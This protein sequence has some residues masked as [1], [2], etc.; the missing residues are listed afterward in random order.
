MTKIIKLTLILFLIGFIPTGYANADYYGYWQRCETC[1]KKGPQCWW[2]GTD[3]PLKHGCPGHAVN[4]EIVTDGI[5][6]DFID[7]DSIILSG[8]SI[9]TA[10]QHYDDLVIDFDKPIS[11]S[12]NYSVK[13]DGKTITVVREYTESKNYFASLAFLFVGLI[14]GLLLGRKF[15]RR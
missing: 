7:D 12:K 15:I 1:P 10:A 2:T 9:N 3:K 6:I 13:R 4:S 8:N 14:I 11:D 5:M